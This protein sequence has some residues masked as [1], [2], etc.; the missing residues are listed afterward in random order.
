MSK[1]S[2]PVDIYAKRMQDIARRLEEGLFKLASSKVL[3]LDFLICAEVYL[4]SLRFTL[5]FHHSFLL[6]C[7]QS[8]VNCS[9]NCV[10]LFNI[11]Y[12]MMIFTVFLLLMCFDMTG[13]IY[14][15]GYS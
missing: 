3:L 11:K 2:H 13:G 14:E 4:W 9:F 8:S 15:L 10:F 6:M 1:S 5:Y 12:E 7:F